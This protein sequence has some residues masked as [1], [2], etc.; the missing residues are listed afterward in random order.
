MKKRLMSLLLVLTMVLGLLPTGAL[1]AEGAAEISDQIGLAGMTDGSYILT[2]DITLSEWTAIDFSGTL[3][4]NG[5]TITLNG[6]P[7][8]K[9]LSGTVQNL[10]LVGEAAADDAAGALALSLNGG[11]V[12]NCWSGADVMSYYD[13]A[14]GF[15]GTVV[16]GTIRNCLFAG[17]YADYG[18][19]A[20]AD[21]GSRIENCY[22]PD[23]L[24]ASDGAFAAKDNEGI[25]ADRYPYAMANL[26][27][28]HEDGLLYW[29]M[30]TDGVPKPISSK[31]PEANRT[32]L[33]TLYDEVKD[34]PNSVP[35]EDGISYTE[36]S[37]TAFEAARTAAQT[38]LRDENATQADIDEAKGRLQAALD[39]LIPDRTTA[40]AEERAALQA[41]IAELPAEKG[42]YTDASWSAVQAALKPVESLL[43]NPAA[44][45]AE[46]TERA[47]ALE[48]AMAALAEIPEP[49]AVTEPPEGQTWTMSSTA[50]QLAELSTGGGT[51]YYKLANDIVDYVGTYDPFGTQIK[52]FNGV[53]DGNGFT[54]TFADGS[55]YPNPIVDTLGPNGII[56]NLGVRGSISNPALVNKLDGKLI[57]CYSWADSHYGGL[58]GEMRSGSI[59]ANCYVNQMPGG[60]SSGGLVYTGSGGHILN[61]YWPSGEAIGDN[62]N[63]SI[64]DSN[65]AANQKTEE[66]RTLLNAHRF[67]GME[68]HQSELGLPWLGEEQDYVESTFYPVVMTDLITGETTTI[69]SA[70]EML[71]TSVF[72]L[73]NGNVATLAVQGYEGTVKWDVTSEQTNAPIIVYGAGKVWV[74]DPG[75]VTVTAVCGDISFF[76]IGFAR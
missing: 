49:A 21:S 1:A 13:S 62:E 12:N 39:G 53:L 6:A 38:V 75:T 40:T 50:E 37:W 68:W 30:D 58:V 22:Y 2:Q 5:H 47:T 61:S 57:N 27:S 10:L 26:N 14:A 19:A 23:W 8:F 60:S 31:K 69:T 70:D 45:A 59:I 72:G 3:D 11:T 15:I 25:R 65:T 18:I 34:K 63:T 51:G 32:E 7:L 4:G 46:L 44:T 76:S 54:V 74:R 28:A 41:K 24:D 73:P 9:E 33:Q 71:T 48:N 35:G 20:T 36:D 55:K 56:Q 64:L 42:R 67:G 17:S 52:P 29:D 16:S 43:K 66:F